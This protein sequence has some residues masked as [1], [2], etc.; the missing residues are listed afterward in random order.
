MAGAIGNAV[1][2]KRKK[3]AGVD[4]VT[5]AFE[6]ADIDCDKKVITCAMN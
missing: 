2:A 4:E 1:A 3:N 5:K 6:K